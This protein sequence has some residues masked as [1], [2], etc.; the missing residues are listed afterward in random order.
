[1]HLV[2]WSHNLKTQK[3]ILGVI[4]TLGSA[5]PTNAQDRGGRN[6]SDTLR[7]EAIH[8]QIGLGD[9]VGAQSLYEQ[10]CLAG[11]AASCNDAGD[12]YHGGVYVKNRGIKIDTDRAD[13]F[14]KMA[15]DGGN[16][17][18]CD[19]IERLGK[20]ATQQSERT[21]SPPRRANVTPHAAAAQP[22]Y[23]LSLLTFQQWSSC[24]GKELAQKQLEAERLFSQLDTS[25]KEKQQRDQLVR[26]IADTCR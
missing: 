6:E 26:N 14:Y 4:L 9:L 7:S 1:M 5:T 8:H 3:L 2:N 21:V 24:L 15:C 17:P 25:A 13:K 10:S 18:A 16:Q 20:R 19:T 23:M 11:N 12:F 22:S